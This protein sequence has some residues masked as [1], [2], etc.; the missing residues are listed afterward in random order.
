MALALVES[1]PHGVLL[2]VWV[3]AASG[4]PQIA[5]H[6][7]SRAAIAEQRIAEARQ[8]VERDRRTWTE[9]LHYLLGRQH[10][11]VVCRVELDTSLQAPELLAEVTEIWPHWRALD[12][13]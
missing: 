4:R 13:L 8:A 7:P 1:N 9:F 12:H 5:F 2:G 11:Q 6:D 3:D 10:P